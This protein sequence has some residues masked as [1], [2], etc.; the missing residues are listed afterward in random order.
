MNIE[1]EEPIKHATMA[2]FDGDLKAIAI[3]MI[4]AN[5]MPEVHF[6][7]TP[8]TAFE[9]N[10]GVDILKTEMMIMLH[11]RMEERKPRE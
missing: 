3:V 8:E 6:R 1:F 7:C 4:T 5:G 2:N 10:A 11:K 9:M